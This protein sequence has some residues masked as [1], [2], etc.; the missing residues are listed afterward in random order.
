MISALIVSDQ[1]TL[2]RR[3]P[4]LRGAWLTPQGRRPAVAGSKP[5]YRD[6]V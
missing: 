1:R 2:T 6:L 4:P 5:R 3:A